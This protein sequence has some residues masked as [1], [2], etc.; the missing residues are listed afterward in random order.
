MQMYNFYQLLSLIFSYSLRLMKP[1]Y[2]LK[3]NWEKDCAILQRIYDFLNDLTII[4][5]VANEPFHILIF[6]QFHLFPFKYCLLQSSEG[7]TYNNLEVQDNNKLLNFHIFQQLLLSKNKRV[8]I[9]FNFST[10]SK[11]Y[12]LFNF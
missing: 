10:C 11:F 4:N 3:Q 12:Q 1:Q 7:S 8:N 2:V 6:F 9:D 5:S